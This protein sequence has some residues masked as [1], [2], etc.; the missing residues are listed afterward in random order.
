VVD[1]GQ[2][3]LV[4]FVHVLRTFLRWNPQRST[5]HGGRLP[6]AP[7]SLQ[8]RTG[9]EQRRAD[10]RACCCALQRAGR[11]CGARSEVPAY[12]MDSYRRRLRHPPCLHQQLCA[13]PAPRAVYVPRRRPLLE[14][15]P[16]HSCRKLRCHTVCLVLRTLSTALP[17]NLARL[18]TIRHRTRA[19][20]D[21]CRPLA[22]A[23][24]SIPALP[25]LPALP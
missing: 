18:P 14:A 13:L 1:I 5:A 7:S 16:S 25:A 15:S 2:G 20:A 17:C 8:D 9:L 11:Q 4:P 24:T 6:A 12:D 10:A 21:G 3:A 23:T 19:I 22:A